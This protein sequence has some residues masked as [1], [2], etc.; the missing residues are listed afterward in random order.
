MGLGLTI[1]KLICEK[2]NGVIEAKS[3]VGIGTQFTFSFRLEEIRNNNIRVRKISCKY[4]FC[5]IGSD[6][7]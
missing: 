3:E 2:M 4:L 5:Q 1:S 7:K 6:G